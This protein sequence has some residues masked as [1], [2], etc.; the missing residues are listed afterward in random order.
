MNA[1]KEFQEKYKLK[2]REVAKLLE[3]S[4]RQICYLKAGKYKITLKVLQR[5]KDA[6]KQFKEKA[7]QTVASF[8]SALTS[9]KNGQ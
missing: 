3:R 5:L 2:T 9:A 6:E 7:T 1:I 4:E 8:P